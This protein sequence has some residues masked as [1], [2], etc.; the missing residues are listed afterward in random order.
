MSKV[1]RLA[2]YYY[3]Y[4]ELPVFKEKT[5]AW[6]KKNISHNRVRSNAESERLLDYHIAKHFGSHGKVTYPQK[7]NEI[8][9][10]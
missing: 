10:K 8:L 7:F 2:D 1:L 4:H 9:R 3:E 6:L 5:E